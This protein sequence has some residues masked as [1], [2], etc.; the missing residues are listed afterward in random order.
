MSHEI[1]TPMNAIIG[2]TELLLQE[3]ELDEMQADNLRSIQLSADNLLEIINDI[4]DIS[5]I[6]AGKLSLQTSEFNLNNVLQQV[7][8][9]AS[10]KANSKKIQLNKSVDTRLP[11]MLKGDAVRLNQILINLVD[12]ALKF[13]ENGNVEVKLTAKSLDI[14][15]AKLIL[16]IEVVDSGIGIPREKFNIIFESFRQIKTSTIANMVA[17]VWD[18]LLPTNWLN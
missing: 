10:V 2:L 13:T 11:L 14:Q 4:L 7:L 1:R 5:K 8:R 17:Q 16:H 12:N 3:N 9:V 6:D 15:N 18:L